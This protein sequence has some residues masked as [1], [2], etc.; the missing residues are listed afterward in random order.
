VAFFFSPIIF[1]GI[2]KKIPKWIFLLSGWLVLV[3]RVAEVALDTKGKMLVSG[4][5]VAAF[6]VFFPSC[7]GT[8][9]TDEPKDRGRKL[10]IGLIFALAL[11]MLFR[12]LQSGFDIT[13]AGGFQ[14]IGWILALT[15]AFLLWEFGRHETTG[16]TPE[17]N[18]GSKWRVIV[19]SCGL[20]AVFLLLYFAFTSPNVIARW[21]EVNYPLILGLILLSLCL[22][23]WLWFV[24]KLSS[25]KR[26]LINIFNLVFV[27]SMVLTILQ[28]QIGF[29]ASPDGYPL[30]EP[31]LP[32][33]SIVPLILMLI[34]FPVSIL[35]FV[36]YSLEIMEERPTPRTL[37]LGF[38]VASLFTLIMILAHVFTTV[39]D[40]IPVIGPFFRDKFWLVHL[41]VGIVAAGPVLL[42]R[43]EKFPIEVFSHAHKKSAVL[44]AVLVGV[45]VAVISAAF[46]LSAKPLPPAA[47]PTE[48]R[49]LTYNIQQGF[50]EDGMKNFKG[51][52]DLIKSL[53]PDIIGLQESDTNRIAGGNSDI[54]RYFADQLDMY[55]YYGPS[56]VTG[57]FGIA[58]LSRFP[59]EEAKTFYMYSVGEQTALIE[60]RIVI[61]GIEYAI[62]VTHLGNEGPIVQQVQVLEVL[63]GKKNI[64]AMG[65]FNFRPDTEQYQ[66]TVDVLEDAYIKSQKRMDV[67]QFDPS[68]RI[69]H[70]F[71]SP[72]VS[73]KE[74]EYIL[75]S[76]SDHP[77]MFA[78]I[79][80][81]VE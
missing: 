21:T 39:Y 32:A 17:R 78:V 73:V 20:E 11:S 19:F 30:L 46:L 44:R 13:S 58:L 76:H 10:G 2:R 6:L 68:Q 45:A 57:T 29:P 55:S 9:L 63:E 48:L 77:A 60:A 53:A 67:D 5:G 15:A 61:G 4:L 35:N 75:S 43:K 1:L 25:L 26:T 62:F 56:P 71:V 80:L 65:D 28:V 36:L 54:V 69:D 70:I 47:S 64:V 33:L 51:Q 14:A 72:E 37:G 52:L 27:F 34:T 18:S 24:G 41:L 74:A 79:S 3:C 50:S 81:T 31:E 59:I 42:V 49:V 12:A 22:F 66:L 7:L 40:Y 38:S 16:S 23:G 8:Q